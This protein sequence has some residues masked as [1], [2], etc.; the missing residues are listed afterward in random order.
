MLGKLVTWYGIVNP[1]RVPE[2]SL[3]LRISVLS[4][5]LAAE[6]T[7]LTMGYYDHLTMVVV[8]VLTTMG[9]TVSWY[10]RRQRN[11]FLKG[12]LS[13]LVMLAAL[14]F[15]RDLAASFYDTRLPLI[16][17]L[18]WLQVL[19]SFDLPARKDLKFSLASGLILL[20]AGAVLS[21]SMT[22]AM[23]LAAYSFTATVALIFMHVSEASEKVDYAEPLR[24]SHAIVYGAIVLALSFCLAVPILLLVPQSTQAKFHPLPLSN[25]QKILGDFSGEVINPYYSN[26]NPFEGSP[27][28]QPDSYYGFNPYLDLRSRGHL[29]DDIVLKVR[30]DS[31]DFYRG[32]VFDRYNGKGWEISSQETTDLTADSPP[33]D[34]NLPSVPVLP[35]RTKVESFYVQADLPNIIFSSFRPL[36]LYFPTNH[37]K[38]DHYGS[39]RSPYPLTSDTVYSAL[40]EAPVYSQALL[41]HF[42]RSIDPPAD[43]TY[44]ELPSSPYLDEV[45]K[46]AKEI[47]A[48]YVSRYDQ[49][50]A[51]ERYLKDNYPYDL[52][53]P[54]QSQDMDAV[55]Y[56]LFKQKA[57]YCE[58]FASALAVLARSTGIPARVV[59]GYTGGSYN[60]FTGLWEIRQSDAH[61]WVEVYFGAAGW[62][63]FD[64]TPGFDFPSASTSGQSSWPLV[65]IFSYL[66]GVLGWEPARNLLKTIGSGFATAMSLARSLPLVL[67]S[68]TVI[69][70]IALAACAWRL[71]KQL[72]KKQRRRRHLAASLSSEYLSKPVL[73][74]YLDLAIQLH[75]RGLARRPEETL[76][77]FSRRVSRVL[78]AEEFELLSRLVEQIRYGEQVKC[79]GA[80]SQASQLKKAVLSKLKHR[81][82]GAGASA[83]RQVTRS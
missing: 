56:F 78:N 44:T 2:D 59:T 75:A 11:L 32:V 15:L 17:M 6:I 47:T 80:A 21:T 81:P 28:Y 25:L 12:I 9:F 22:Y 20:A 79:K 64:P 10:R 82:A 42:P 24:P 3:P 4:S 18:L 83:G 62:V 13:V 48:P 1:K 46:L 57:G 73:K 19:H 35:T 39:L 16:K 74:D 41:S 40:I 61:A 43:P 38:V 34:L 65:R 37:I 76:R 69:A 63:P 70:A 72:T 27:Q 30:S 52:D 55:A 71:L 31:Y 50:K 45:K 68:V 33:F 23:G 14:M 8:P 36:L 77:N 58:H 54:P 67:I 49:V 29:S 26:G 66:N 7:I 51:I 53:V 5:I 60:P